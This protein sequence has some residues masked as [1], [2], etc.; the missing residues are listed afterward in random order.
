VSIL[1][2]DAQDNETPGASTMFT[3]ISVIE[4]AFLD[5]LPLGP[6]CMVR[7]G[8]KPLFSAKEALFGYTMPPDGYWWEHSTPARY[9]QGN[10]N[11][12]DNNLISRLSASF[13]REPWSSSL[14]HTENASVLLGKGVTVGSG[15]VFSKM[16]VAGEG[17]TIAPSLTLENC[18]IWPHS[19][20][21]QSLSH[22]II[23]PRGILDVPYETVQGGFTGPALKSSP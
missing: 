9:L 7:Q 16:V 22:S 21:T 11:L 20:V 12:F 18:V 17:V 1:G 5:F 13:D 2:K 8:W 14:D 15:V 10:M 19:H 3:G 23:T 4:P 6:S